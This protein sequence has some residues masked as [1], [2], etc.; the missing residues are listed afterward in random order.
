MSAKHSQ[1]SRP[2]INEVV[3]GFIFEPTSLDVLD[4]GVY[5][6]E[7]RSAFPKRELH[8]ALVD[9]VMLRVG[10]P[11]SGLRAWLISDDD[12][13]VLQL[14]SD[15]LYLNWRRRDDHYPRFSSH[16]GRDGLKVR[17]LDEFERFCRFAEQRIGS[18]LNL[19]RVEL[20]K[21]DRLTRGV[22]YTDSHDLACLLKVA[23]VFEDIAVSDKTQL[24]LQLTE[25][26]DEGKLAVTIAA[27][28][29]GVR[30]DTRYI[31]EPGLDL[32]SALDVAN[33]RLN[34]VFFGLVDARRF[35]LAEQKP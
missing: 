21:I 7:R 17:A 19:R 12:Q 18:T 16:E 27:S 5:A 34:T 2:P 25:D 32:S 11:G 35:G 6:E 3:C 31:L 22:D 10:L 14:Q 23:S 24:R 15:R 20:T 30:L 8:T 13:F 28:E 4:F 26:A 29:E 33:G 1:L 9:G